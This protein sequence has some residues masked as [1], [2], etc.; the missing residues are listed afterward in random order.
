[1]SKKANVSEAGQPEH[2]HQSVVFEGEQTAAPAPPLKG[3][4]KRKLRAPVPSGYE[5]L[6]VVLP[7]FRAFVVRQWAAE[8][9]R[10][11]SEST[12]RE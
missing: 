6:D 12:L 11:F 3:R 9:E 10:A 5:A 4:S 2:D 1:V 7:A 8:A